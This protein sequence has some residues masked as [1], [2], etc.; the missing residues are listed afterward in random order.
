MVIFP[1]QK[2]FLP[3]IQLREIQT[4]V[5]NAIFHEHVAY[6]IEIG[7]A[8]SRSPKGKTLSPS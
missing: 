5:V 7:T 8:K 2:N 3:T 1:A 4:G 6:K